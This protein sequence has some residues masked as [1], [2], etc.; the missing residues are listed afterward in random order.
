M[1]KYCR[2][3]SFILALL[4]L[5]LI[6]T[7]IFN[8]RAEPFPTT[9]ILNKNNELEVEGSVDAG[10]SGRNQSSVFENNRLPDEDLNSPE[11]GTGNNLHNNTAAGIDADLK[12]KWNGAN[13]SYNFDYGAEFRLQYKDNTYYTRGLKVRESYIFIKKDDY[14]RFEIGR[15]ISASQ[16]MKVGG[17]TLAR[18]AGGISGQYLDYINLPML[19]DASQ[20]SGSGVI[21]NSEENVKLP[22][23]IVKP[24]HPTAHGGYAKGYNNPAFS[25]YGRYKANDTHNNIAGDFGNTQY[26]PKIT[27]YSPRLAGF[28]AGISYTDYAGTLTSANDTNQKGDITNIFDWGLSYVNTFNNIGLALSITGENGEF[29]ETNNSSRKDLNSIV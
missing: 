25:D 8:S 3:L 5:C 10:V 1:Q 21:S 7:P 28:K 9:Y 17:D 24:Q 29:S 14:G 18:G 26:A 11:S 19:G 15:N 12:I 16:E 2:T 27:Y 6:L 20:A 4:L 13:N 22:R 23:F